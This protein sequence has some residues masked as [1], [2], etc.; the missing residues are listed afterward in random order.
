[1]NT[2]LIKLYLKFQDL[3]SRE[4]G[5]D[6]VEYALA[7]ALISLGAT[8]SMTSLAGGLNIAFTGL[9]TE[10]GSYVS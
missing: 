6:I 1:M 10:L 8:A 2:I 9:S 3:V 5:Q 4:E 7:F